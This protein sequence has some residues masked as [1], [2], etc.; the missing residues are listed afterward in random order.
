VNTKYILKCPE[1]AEVVDEGEVSFKCHLCGAPSVV[2]LNL[3]TSVNFQDSTSNSLWRFFDLLPIIDSTKIV[4]QGE[5]QTP[6]LSAA[7]LAQRIGIEDLWLKNETMNPTGAFKDR[8]ISVSITKAME[9]GIKEIAVVSSGNVAASAASYA[10][11]AGMNCRIFTP[12]NAPDDRLVQARIYGACHYKMNTLSSSLIFELVSRACIKRGWHLLSTAGIY[13]P[14]QVEGAKTIAYEIYEQV[15]PLPRWIIVPVGGGGLLGALWRGFK[16]LMRLKKIDH[17][18]SLVGVQASACTPLIRAI[19]NN[20]SPREVIENPVSV[21]HTIAGAIA[22][23]ILFDAYT[24]L[25]AIR[26]T[27]GFA[28]SV[29]DDEMLAAEKLIAEKAGIFAEPASA[30]TV[31]ALIHMRNS[32]QVAAKDRIC[33]VI[34]GSGFKDMVVAKSMVDPPIGIEASD[35]AFSHLP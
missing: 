24:A 25:P 6:C 3:S 12:A 35:K 9:S 18:P 28:L 16:E 1:C 15:D 33:C 32:G 2:D 7:K 14:F 13:N 8:Q 29:N 21:G 20:L 11:R 4:S 22:D 19:E 30:T 34:T 10:A 27:G 5:G 31:A 23:D 26:E 17:I